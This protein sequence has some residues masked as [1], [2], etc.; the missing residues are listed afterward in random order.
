MKKQVSL[1]LVPVA[2]LGLVLSGC[3]S[4]QTAGKPTARKYEQDKQYIAAVE[5]ATRRAGLTVIWVNPPEK[6]VESSDN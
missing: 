6:K 3:A 2:L 5:N 4:T 1:L